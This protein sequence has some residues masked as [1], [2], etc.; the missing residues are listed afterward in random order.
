MSDETRVVRTFGTL[1]LVLSIALVSPGRAG[2]NWRVNG[3]ET[4]VNQ[5]LEVFQASTFKLLV[6]KQG[7][8]IFCKEMASEGPQTI[9]ALSSEGKGALKFSSCKTLFEGTEQPNCKPV[10]PIVVGIKANL[11]LHNSL[12]YV[13]FSP[14]AEN[15][16][17]E[18]IF[19]LIKTT[20][21]CIPFEEITVRGTMVAECLNGELKTGAKYCES[22]TV[23]HYLQ[24]ASAE[25]F[26]ENP[27]RLGKEPTVSPVSFDGVV[28]VR[29]F[30]GNQWSGII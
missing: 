4:F 24:Q 7:Y 30:S 2:A 21:L 28:G 12:T 15:K 25:L 11:I 29:L 26:T 13:L 18:K 5:S 22:E 8:E 6:P 19:A 9:F 10:E 23:T 20:G 17:G 1:L 16:F 14:T 27:L 3:G